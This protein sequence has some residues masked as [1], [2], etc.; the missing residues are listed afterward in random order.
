MPQPFSISNLPPYANFSAS[1]LADEHGNRD[2][3]VSRLRDIDTLMLGHYP[4]TLGL[5][6]HYAAQS[7]RIIKNAD[8]DADDLPEAIDHY[9][10][11][12]DHVL[13]DAH[14]ERTSLI[15]GL[16]RAYAAEAL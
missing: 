4:S 2:E 9:R 10:S 16:S 1:V 13:M 11:F 8:P 15:G 5:L 3:A 7:Y 6:Q 14:F 12:G